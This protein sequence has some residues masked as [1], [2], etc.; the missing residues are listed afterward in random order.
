MLL[1]H[2]MLNLLALFRLFLVLAT[3]FFMAYHTQIF[4]SRIEPNP[5][6]SWLASIVIEG[7]L[8]SL[9][10]SK[11]VLSRILLVPV[12][13]VSVIAASASFVVQ[14]EKLLDNFFRDRRVIEQLEKHL[15]EIKDDYQFGQKYITKTLQRERQ[16]QDELREILKKQE[17]EVTIF[18]ALT[19]F[20]FILVMQTSSVYT[21]ATLKSSFREFSA[22]VSIEN[23]TEN[24]Q[25]KTVIL[26]PN[27]QNFSTEFSVENRT[28]NLQKKTENYGTEPSTITSPSTP[29]A[30]SDEDKKVIV[31]RLKKARQNGKKLEDLARETGLSVSTLSKVLAWPGYQVSEETFK[32]LQQVLG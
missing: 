6:F 23:R 10:L 21:A 18:N 14:N 11:T 4:I 32:K 25:K 30:L 16:L 22:E 2:Q 31:T 3:G 26:E 29:T 15:Q 17:G 7:F 12:F 28:E 27:F 13:L 19:F 8:I 24:S 5:L 9:A 1:R 20:I